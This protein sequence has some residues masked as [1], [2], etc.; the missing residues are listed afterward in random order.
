MAGM[1]P[2]Y[3]LREWDN[4]G[5]LL[6]GGFIYLYESGTLV[7]K[8]AFTDATYSIPLPNPV[9]LDAG[10]AA[11]I[12]LGNGA[13]RA[14]VKDR[15]GVQVRHAIDGI[16][17]G[18]GGASSE[19]N[20]TFALVAVYDDLRSLTDVVDLVYVSGR[21]MEGDGG[22]GWFQLLPGGQGL[23]D[24]DGI[25]LASGGGANIYKRNI[26]GEID[27]R[28]YG[29][30]Y[31]A[32]VDNTLPLA[33]A[34]LGSKN[35]NYP[36]AVRGST[37]IT[38]TNTIPTGADVRVY[39]DG[40]FTAPV[41]VQIIFDAGSNLE[42]V[43]RSFGTNVT[44]II[45][46]G[47]ANRICLSWMG[48]SSDNERFLKFAASSTN[49]IMVLDDNVNIG[50]DVAFHEGTVLEPDGGVI[51]V[52]GA[53]KITIPGIT[54]R[55]TGAFFNYASAVN[56]DTLVCGKGPARPEWFGAVGDGVANDSKALYLAAKT[57]AIEVSA[58]YKHGSVWPTIPTPLQIAG[59]GSIALG[60]GITLGTGELSLRNCV[61]SQ[62]IAGSTWF[63]GSF[64]QAF[65]AAFPS[66]YTATSEVV[67]GCVYTDDSRFP[68]YNGKPSLYNGHLP[69]ILKADTLATDANGK[70]Y[71]KNLNE[72]DA[73]WNINA[74][75]TAG[76]TGNATRGFGETPT[77]LIKSDGSTSF[78]I[79]DK[80]NTF[81]A[82]SLI[83]PSIPYY[84]ANQRT[85]EF[86]WYAGSAW[87]AATSCTNGTD[88]HAEIFRSTDPDGINAW[89]LLNTAP[90]ATQYYQQWTG[91]KQLTD[92]TV[93]IT[94]GA[95]NDYVYGQIYKVS[96]TAVTLIPY[97]INVANLKILALDEQAGYIYLA[98]QWY[99][100]TNMFM[101][102]LKIS[103]GTVAN[104][105]GAG[106][107]QC[108]GFLGTRDT[109]I[110][111]VGTGNIYRISNLKSTPFA[112]VF[113]TSWA[114]FN[115]GA[116]RTMV[117][118]DYTVTAGSDGGL[119]GVMQ[120]E[121][122]WQSSLSSGSGNNR[123]FSRRLS[124]VEGNTFNTVAY[125]FTCSYYVE[126]TGET[127]LGG[128]GSSVVNRY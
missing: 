69:L 27:P 60:P 87:Y 10:G 72:Y 120:S 100:Y 66:T 111:G 125:N 85:I 79:R 61:I 44:P 82:W 21:I 122:T 96:S 105:S 12:W 63:A 43:G 55:E 38:Q 119:L 73:N 15:N 56:A 17:G 65:D 40:F 80:F 118:A 53:C 25:V 50:T 98:A 113:S 42:C 109:A 30:K 13:Y 78:W 81:A 1:F 112:P 19:S 26:D 36:L 127:L 47:V 14:I 71:G 114:S 89:T 76:G 51:S 110:A 102:R 45:A 41:E 3:I 7:P 95:L 4:N 106:I 49:A 68:V 101:L 74:L 83:T 86:V 34:A 117:N 2:N 9:P 57:G 16:T 84:Y 33:N 115:M 88:F 48:G 121:D 8:T 39:D 11:D 37:Y 18:G 128:T 94:K 124:G 28:W 90:A 107:L 108:M 59:N 29:V 64:L 22:A 67:S 52:Y 6:S 32:S 31:D 23:H 62:A 91:F 35:F 104:V 20:I 116:I 70:I 58:T 75:T 77:H 103:D 123:Y 97:G 126:A 93:Y 46:S 92:G 24:D 54:N 99:D 5:T